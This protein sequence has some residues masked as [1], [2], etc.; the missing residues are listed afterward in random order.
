MG[1][2]S[3]EIVVSLLFF[4]FGVEVGQLCFVL[5][6]LALA[7]AL[8]TLEFHWPRWVDLLPGYAVGSLGAFWTVQRV[9]MMF[10]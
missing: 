2:P 1:L 3:Q 8:R 4:N 9:V 7:R 6:A 5:L 10:E